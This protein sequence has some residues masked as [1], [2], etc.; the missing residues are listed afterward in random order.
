M[1]WKKRNKWIFG[2][3]NQESATDMIKCLLCAPAE[4]STST[5][6]G[7]GSI[8]FKKV[9]EFKLQNDIADWLNVPERKVNRELLG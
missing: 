2:P 3:Y 1:F 6:R 4:W 7:I 5:M 9:N 8:K